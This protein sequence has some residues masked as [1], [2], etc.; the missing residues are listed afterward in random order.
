MSNPKNIAIFHYKVGGTDGV[1][2]E[3]EKWKR[4]LESLGQRVFLC[5]GE[6][7]QTDGYCIEELDQHHPQMARLYRNSFN[8]LI[9][10]DPLA[11]ETDLLCWSDRLEVKLL[12]FLGRYKIDLINVHNIWSVALNPPLAVALENVRQKLS[13]PAL[14]H[15]HDFYWERT[16]GIAV[17]NACA[18]EV[19]DRYLPPRTDGVRAYRNQ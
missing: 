9:D 10:F 4:V 8:E 17:T 18:L 5:A 19:V 14:A 13:L 16:E 11:Y 6:L 3:I 1:S 12:E 2:L 7:G 15:H